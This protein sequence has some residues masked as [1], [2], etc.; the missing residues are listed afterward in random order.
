MQR[1]E[2]SMKN[3]LLPVA[4]TSLLA[5][6]LQAAA[7]NIDLN[8]QSDSAA[9][10][11]DPILIPLDPAIPVDIDPATGDITATAEAGFICGGGCQVSLD[12]ADDAF[13]TVNGGSSATVPENGSV[14]FNWQARGAWNCTG[15]LQDSTGATVTSTV[16]PGSGK[17]PFG[18]QTVT[19]T[20]LLPDVY[21]AGLTC[22]NSGETV[23][24]TPVT[25]E[26]ESSGL[27]IPTECQGRQPAAS[28]SA[29][30]DAANESINCFS[31]ANVFGGFPGSQN[32]I[33]Y[34]QQ[35]GTYHAMEFDTTGTTSEEGSWIFET[36]QGFFADGTGRKIMTISRCP[37]D[38]DQDLITAEMGANCYSQISGFDN[39]RWKL[40][41]T[42]GSGRCVLQ[43][44]ETYW[45]NIIYT[46][47]PEGT[48]H[49]SLEW[50][51]QSDSAAQNCGNL[52]APN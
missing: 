2:F 50:E 8:L 15:T 5:L 27:E 22:T 36:P 46:T 21:T 28:P 11:P 49:A 3:S 47:D 6:S 14:T 1:P 7:Q 32:S 35:R 45:L 13:F 25:I 24:A 20:N 18:P 42:A 23:A 44:G 43:E 10:D 52:M 34:I 29:V 48:D 51:C 39:L 41:G 16:W 19:L 37:G 30:C 4:A 12:P 40:A 38:F 17:L 33:E 9:P 26:V 31:Y